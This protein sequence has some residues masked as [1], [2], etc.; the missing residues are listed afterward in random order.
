[1]T[2]PTYE[3]PADFDA[4]W[5]AGFRPYEVYTRNATPV[6]YCGETRAAGTVDGWEI[7]HVFAKRSELESFPFFDAVICGS[8]MS[9]V[10]ATHAPN[11]KG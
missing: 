5:E 8:D 3:R 4:M 11:W 10:T 9:V 7:V 2:A 6:E 1:M